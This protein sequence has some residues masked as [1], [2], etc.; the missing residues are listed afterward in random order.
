MIANGPRTFGQR[1]KYLRQQRGLKQSELAVLI[2]KP[3]S[4]ISSYEAD[5]RSPTLQTLQAL[6]VALGSRV[7][8]LI[9]EQ[10]E[11]ELPEATAWPER[12]LELN[13][14]VA[15]LPPAEQD[16]LLTMLRVVAALKLERVHREHG[17][18]REQVPETAY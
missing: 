10:G 13:G 11:G 16:E 9:G 6:A 12:L 1:L 17:R 7:S 14:Y 3:Q 4:S 8:V 15:Q 2:D 5:E 18:R